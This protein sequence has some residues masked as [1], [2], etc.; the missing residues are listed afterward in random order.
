MFDR[1]CESALPRRL[2]ALNPQPSTLNPRRTASLST[3]N[4]KP[5]EDLPALNPQPST[6]KPT[7]ILQNIR[8]VMGKA[9]ATLVIGECGIEE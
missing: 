9:K 7:A 8:K 2:P 1:E 5:M 4:A 3:L 6:Q